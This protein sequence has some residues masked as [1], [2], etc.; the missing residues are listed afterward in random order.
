LAWNKY[1]DEC[2]PLNLM[3]QAYLGIKPVRRNKKDD[4]ESLLATLAAF[5]GASKKP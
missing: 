4:A 5:P 3:V 2:P 1:C